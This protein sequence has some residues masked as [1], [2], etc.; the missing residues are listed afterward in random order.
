MNPNGA[1]EKKEIIPVLTE[2]VLIVISS[3][4]CC[5]TLSVLYIQY[6]KEKKYV[7]RVKPSDL[8]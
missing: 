2:C 6:F 3:L 5:S 8:V 7:I 1:W 4:H